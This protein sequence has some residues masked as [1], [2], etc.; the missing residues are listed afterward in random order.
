[1]FRIIF[2]LVLL[3]FV[4]PISASGEK[5]IITEKD[6]NETIFYNDFTIP[7]TDELFIDWDKVNLLLDKL[8][9]EIY[10]KPVN[11]TLDKNDQII[12]EKQGARLNRSK[13]LTIFMN[14]FYGQSSKKIKLPKKNTFPKVDSE[15]LSEIKS[16]ELES[17]QTYFIESNKER[18]INI[19]LAVKAINNHVVFPY[20]EFSFNNVVGERT[21][22]RGYKKAPVIVKGE[23]AEDI[24]GGICQ[25]SSTLFNAVNLKGIEIVER[26]SHSRSV[27]YVPPGKDATVSWWGPDFV[28]KNNYSHPVLIRAKTEG[29]KV[30]V[31]LYSSNDAYHR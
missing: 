8:E 22:E 5:L 21:K 2:I 25:V 10:Q 19:R 31:T 1:M 27:P 29:G 17:Y 7:Y 3:I 28:F 4:G 14:S 16:N 6:I 23:L 18:T 30:I 12:P 24:G 15:L 13:F 9:N 20:E 11:A 26:Y